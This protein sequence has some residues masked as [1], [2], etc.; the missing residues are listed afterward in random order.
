MRRDGKPS[1]FGEL[2][3]LGDAIA[4]LPRAP[5]KPRQESTDDEA[6]AEAEAKRAR[7]AARNKAQLSR[8]QA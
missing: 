7:R 1:W 2:N 6:R 3:G 4:N 5:W 8:K